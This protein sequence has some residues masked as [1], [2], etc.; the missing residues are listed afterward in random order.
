MTTPEKMKHLF[1]PKSIAII[2]ASDNP[3]R[4][5]GR[6]ISILQN[7]GFRGEIFPV[8]PKYST[9]QGLT[10]YPDAASLP[11]A[12]DLFLICLPAASAVD[13]LEEVVKAGGH[14][15]VIFSGGFAE[16]GEEGQAL[17]RRLISITE[18]SGIAVV[19]PNSLGVA[20]FCENSFGTFATTLATLPEIDAGHLALVSQSGGAAF[21]L[22]TEAYWAGARFSHV[23][24]TGNEAGLSFADYLEYLATDENTHAVIGYLEGIKDGGHLRVALEALQRA[25]KPVFLL[26]TG[27]SQRGRVSVASH[28]AQL[29]GDD[30]AFNA[31]FER[32]GVV[33]L[34]SM[35]ELIDVMRALSLNSPSDG[36]AV[37]TNSGGA[38]AYLSDACDHYGVPLSELTAATH[39]ALVEALP[40]FAGLNNPVDFTAQV[41]ND[42]SLLEKTLDILDTDPGVDAILVFLGSMEYLAAELLKTLI[43]V[44]GRLKSPMVVSWLGVSEEIRAT[45]IREGLVVTAD[46]VRLLRG[47]GLVRRA[48]ALRHTEESKVVEQRG[49]EGYGDVTPERPALNEWAVMTLLDG[50]G[51]RTPQR[52]LVHSAD[53]AAA[54]LAEVGSSVVLKVMEPFMAHRAKV[55]AVEIGI[56]TEEG[57]RHAF[58]RM[59][60]EFN[61]TVG[62][63]ERQ[64]P[65]GPE[66]I[67]GLLSDETFGTRAVLGSG[68]VWA[69]EINDA[70]VL[71]PPYDVS[72]VEGVLGS[73]GRGRDLFSGAAPSGDVAEWASNLLNA[74][75][76]VHAAAGDIEEIECNPVIVGKSGL[77]VVDAL[78]FRS[79]S[80]VTA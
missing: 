31:L 1:E 6:P 25:G 12:V 60:R 8:N 14:S 59:Q 80:V 73:L 4:I 45:A 70:A 43:G 42:L 47:L 71:V 22:F 5:G 9:V 76:E 16:V 62:V 17:Q 72:Y 23:I 69:N 33:R 74:L 65:E 54:A 34:A 64:I 29:S 13:A 63:V 48:R 19:G 77:E 18:E 28:T 35:D 78:A 49:N 67:V 75:A 51:I 57:V 58:E 30:S 79:N 53:E 32:T 52:R 46:P 21:N 50:H 2:G 37:A 26:K 20:S 39:S 66:L 44:K 41:I 38:A 10:C 61:M 56:E 27:R 55:G 24:A 11:V 3:N 15:A 7:R 40:S 68:G 36:L